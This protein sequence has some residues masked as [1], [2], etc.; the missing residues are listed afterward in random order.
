MQ[1]AYDQKRWGYLA[2]I[3][4]PLQECRR[5][6]RMIAAEGHIVL[7]TEHLGDD[8]VATLCEISS[9]CVVFT[10]NKAQTHATG[11]LEHVRE[12]PRHLLVLSATVGQT[13]WQL[14]STL[15]PRI[16][17]SYPAP[18]APWQHQTLAPTQWLEITDSHWPTPGDWFLDV[19]E[20][21]G[22]Q[23]LKTVGTPVDDVKH[24][25]ALLGALHAVTD[26][27][28]LHQQLAKAASALVH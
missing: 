7:G 3:T 25:D 18:P 1:L 20:K 2:R 11:L 4:L 19:L 10:G 24:V 21:L 15:E 9:G 6:R 13:Q 22:D 27:E 16:N 8:P 26:H 23:A 28:I 14:R 5:Q 12:H 17:V